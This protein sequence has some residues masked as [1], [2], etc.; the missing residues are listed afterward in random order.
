M[1]S[2]FKFKIFDRVRI[3]NAKFW[4][5]VNGETGMIAETVKAGPD[6]EMYIV[7]LDRD[8]NRVIPT[9]YPFFRNELTPVNWSVS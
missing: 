8:Q 7:I 2:G 9:M 3:E 1:S 6:G 4:T 5:D